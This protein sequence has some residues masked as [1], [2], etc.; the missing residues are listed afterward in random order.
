MG[1]GGTREVLGESWRRGL[2]ARVTAL[3]CHVMASQGL[4]SDGFVVPAYSPEVG[5]V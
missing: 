5:G 3:K 4:T 2:R 1:E